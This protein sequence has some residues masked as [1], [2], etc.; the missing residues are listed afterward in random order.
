MK[1]RTP[2]RTSPGVPSARATRFELVRPE[3]HAVFLA[4]SFNDWHPTTFP[5]LSGDGGKWVKELAL[6]PG[7][8]EYLFVV[9]GVWVADLAVS[10]SVP[11]PHGG[12]NSIIIVPAKAQ[13]V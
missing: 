11:N 3:A 7:R 4:G 10:E 1:K 5:M 12:V 2:D 8:Y 6:P 13:G 9:D